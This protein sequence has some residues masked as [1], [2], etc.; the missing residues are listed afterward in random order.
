[1][2]RLVTA[3]FAMLLVGGCASM[4]EA[5]HLDR[6]FGEAQLASWEQIVAYPQGLHSD[7]I[8]EGQQGIHTEA[9]MK[10]YHRSFAVEPTKTETIKLG[11]AKD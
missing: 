3:L 5:Y 8:P 9:G 4:E 10:V 6:K 1:M 11:I 7:K 2:K